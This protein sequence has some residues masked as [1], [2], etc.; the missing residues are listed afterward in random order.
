MAGFRILQSSQSRYDCDTA[1]DLLV[2]R[3][4]NRGA[5]RDEDIHPR[6]ELHDAESLPRPHHVAL[7]DPADDAPRQYA[8]NLAH[9]N[10]LALMVNRDLGVFVEIPRIVPVRGQETA[11][12]I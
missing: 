10:R 8:D 11:G 7:F 2:D 6:A 3:D 12:M 5:W 4:R 9:D 1:D